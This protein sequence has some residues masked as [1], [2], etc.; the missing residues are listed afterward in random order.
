MQ[1]EV[2][3]DR[4]QPKPVSQQKYMFTST[5]AI[6]MIEHNFIDLMRFKQ[7]NTP[8]RECRSSLPEVESNSVPDWNRGSS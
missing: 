3:E 4:V 8:E 7:K 5:R 6:L 1:A 2:A